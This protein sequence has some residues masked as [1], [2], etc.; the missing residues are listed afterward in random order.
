MKSKPSWKSRQKLNRFEQEE[1]IMTQTRDIFIST[2]WTLYLVWLVFA[3]RLWD[4]I[5]ISPLAAT[6]WTSIESQLSIFGSFTAPLIC[7]TNRNRAYFRFRFVL[8]SKN[9]SSAL[10]IE[11]FRYKNAS[12]AAIV[13]WMTWNHNSVSNHKRKV[14]QATCLVEIIE[15]EIV[16]QWEIIKLWALHEV[17]KQN[18]KE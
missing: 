13:I 9:K 12:T 8:I 18:Q 3:D 11:K 1:N 16:A 4:Q 2:P 10:S 7:I 17:I 14:S 5:N 6:L 15:W